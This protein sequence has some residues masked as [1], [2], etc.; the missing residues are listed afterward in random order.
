MLLRLQAVAAGVDD[1]RMPLSVWRWP[2]LRRYADN[3]TARTW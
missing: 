3:S 1:R 2:R